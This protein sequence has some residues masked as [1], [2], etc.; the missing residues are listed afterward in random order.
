MR[1]SM[2]ARTLLW[3]LIALAISTVPVSAQQEG[4]HYAGLVIVHGDGRVITRCVS[5]SEETISGLDLLRR[6]GLALTVSPF[7][8]MGY[9][10][11]AID[12]EGC[13]EGEACFCQCESA[14][15]R[16]WV[17]SHRRPDGSWALSGVGASGRRLADG[18]VD[19]WVWG[20]GSVAPPHLEFSEICPAQKPSPSPLATPSVPPLETSPEESPLSGTPEVSPFSSPVLE[21]SQARGALTPSLIGYIV[22]GV[23]VVGLIVAFLLARRRRV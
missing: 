6:S 19:G 14:P 2:T 13:G 5:F 21:T 16:Y 18:D 12:G 3:A 17:Y 20:D 8:G 7:G 23:I 11:C 1:N 15:C 22:F 4:P 10:V 9:G